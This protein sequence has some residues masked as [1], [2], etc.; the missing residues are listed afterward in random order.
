MSRD[1]FSDQLLTTAQRGYKTSAN[2]A[3]LRMENSFSSANIS[4]NSNCTLA[5]Q[6]TIDLHNQVSLAKARVTHMRDPTSKATSQPTSSCAITALEI[7]FNYKDILRR[8]AEHR[9]QRSRQYY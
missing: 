5:V 7:L 3:T 2:P 8:I 9:R 6:A 4:R 1:A